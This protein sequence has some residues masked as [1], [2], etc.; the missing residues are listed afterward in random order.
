MDR[1]VRISSTANRKLL[2]T[3]QEALLTSKPRRLF[4]RLVMSRRLSHCPF[5]G[6]ST[7]VIR[8]I[9]VMK[10]ISVCLCIRLGS[11]GGVGI[12]IF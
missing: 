4:L 5:T 1:I 12:L 6:V 10:V 9:Q 8:V 2:K 3:P 7:K 11:R